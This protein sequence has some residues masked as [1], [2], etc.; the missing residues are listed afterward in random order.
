[1]IGLLLPGSHAVA[2]G[3]KDTVAKADPK[4]LLIS[5]ELDIDSEKK[6]GLAES[7]N[8]AIKTI[9]LSPDKARVRLVSLMRVQSIFYSGDTETGAGLITIVKESGKDSYKKK[10][11]QQQWAVMNNKYD[12]AEYIFQEDSIVVLDYMCKKV[13]VKLKDGKTITAYYTTEVN[14]RLFKKVEPAFAGV[15]G[16]V[17]KYE[18]ENKRAKLTYTASNI[19]NSPVDP[20]VYK[21]P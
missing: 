14:N 16:I 19:S 17:L 8:G 7:Y 4:E 1:M 6:N 11:T 2:Q 5:Y 10:I 21:I 13:V 18:Y 3:N 15:P 9:F 20:G 12:G